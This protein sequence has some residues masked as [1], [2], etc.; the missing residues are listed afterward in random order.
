VEARHEQIKN[1]GIIAFL[2]RIGGN[3]N[4]KLGAL[5][6]T[7]LGLAVNF[8]GLT[9]YAAGLI[10]ADIVLAHD[11]LSCTMPGMEPLCFKRNEIIATIT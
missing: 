7:I 8:A 11:K 4:A 9:G 3:Q 5:G 1:L 2:N 10:C 6:H